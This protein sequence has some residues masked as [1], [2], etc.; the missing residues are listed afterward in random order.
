[1]TKRTHYQV[2]ETHESATSDELKKAYRKQSKATHP[3]LHDGDK[4]ME[5]RFK[6]V[7]G[8]YEVL[9]D[10]QKRAKYDA[11]LTRQRAERAREAERK[12]AEQA[13]AARAAQQ[14][15]MSRSPPIESAPTSDGPG[16]GTAIFF[17]AALAG[18][19][20]L[21][22]SALSGND[23]TEWDPNVQRNRGPDGRFRSI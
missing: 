14:Y 21:F 3:D 23:D 22:I 7:Q 1:M 12:R 10:P 6:E 19:G 9:N 20:A 13:D 11:E 5:A 15:S 18:L 16:I 4:T 2:L 8:A 17:G